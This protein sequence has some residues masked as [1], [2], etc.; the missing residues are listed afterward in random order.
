MD[1]KS[2]LEKKLSSP[3]ADLLRIRGIPDMPENRSR[4]RMDA[5][6]SFQVKTS[7][8]TAIT[9]LEA[10]IDKYKTGPRMTMLRWEGHMVS[11]YGGSNDDVCSIQIKAD[12]IGSIIATYAKV[13]ESIIMGVN[14]RVDFMSL[15][16]VDPRL[17]MTMLQMIRLRD[18]LTSVFDNCRDLYRAAIVPIAVILI[19]GTMPH[20]IVRIGRLRYTHD[21]SGNISIPCIGGVARHYA[22]LNDLYF[23]AIG[24]PSFVISSVVA[25]RLVERI[26]TSA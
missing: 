14:Y 2:V 8:A 21:L 22:F 4:V 20:L 11:V 26:F 7:V 1:D 9:L 3:V 18:N 10:S 5:A 6:I 19:Y 25:A 13:R 15:S 17:S 12:S 24:S 16:F 23:P